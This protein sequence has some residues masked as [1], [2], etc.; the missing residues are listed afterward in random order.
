MK[1][2]LLLSLL[3]A[4]SASAAF[5]AGRRGRSAPAAGSAVLVLL[6][7]RGGN[8]GLN[9]LAPTRDPIYRAAR[10]RLAL[11]DAIPLA[12]ELALHPA[13]AP[14]LPA[15]EARR[16]AFA[17]GVG[18]PRPSR[19]HFKA[20]D[21]WAVASPSGDGPGWL[22]AAFDR[23]RTSGPL[24][25]L[26]PS[27]SRA[28]EGGEVVALQLAPSSLRRRGGVSLQPDQ[29]GANPILRRLL[30]LELAGQRE[31]ERLRAAVAPLPGGLEI[32]SG[33]L[34]GQVELALRLIGSGVCPPVLQLAQGGYDTHAAQERSHGRVLA[35]LAAALAAFDAGLRRLQRRPQVTLLAVS[36]FGRRLQE[37]GSGGTDHGAASIALLL[38][39]QV[40]H[41]FLGRYPSLA[42]LDERGDLIAGL[43]PPALYQSALASLFPA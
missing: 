4:G 12:D 24:V 38:G 16:L 22:A 36:E 18:W 2:R 21:Q 7:L 13:M 33:S 32:P 41:P 27:G 17:L 43:D 30:E 42:A 37:N 23:R 20:S 39:D 10:P 3:G 25:A 40:P 14:L 6:E 11:R 31:L 26:G 5:G 19:S 29:A 15:W 9:T 1:R 8:D 35:E 34:G 28:M